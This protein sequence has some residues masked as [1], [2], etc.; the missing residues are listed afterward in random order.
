MAENP[1]E[2]LGVSKI[3]DKETIRKKYIA[4]LK[5]LNQEKNQDAAIEEK[6]ISFTTAYNNLCKTPQ[7]SDDEFPPSYTE[8]TKDD[9]TVSR[10]LY[11]PPSSYPSVTT[12]KIER[13]A[14]KKTSAYP[15]VTHT[16][17]TMFLPAEK[18]PY[19]SAQVKKENMNVPQPAKRTPAPQQKPAKEVKQRPGLFDFDFSGDPAKRTRAE[20]MRKRKLA[21]KKE[22]LKISYTESENLLIHAIA[23]QKSCDYISALIDGSKDTNILY[24][25]DSEGNSLVHIACLMNRLDVVKLLC[26]RDFRLIDARNRDDLDPLCFSLT[27]GLSMDCLKTLEGHGADLSARTSYGMR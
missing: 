5:K 7:L 1:Y 25:R 17:E 3:D 19:P 23:N 4:M 13:L 20:E 21:V 15:S 10:P 27:M 2:I 24:T 22:A 9:A 11:E 16:R 6:R 18:L 8:A 14:E 26:K 12:G